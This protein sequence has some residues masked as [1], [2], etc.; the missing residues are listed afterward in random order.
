M[1]KKNGKK[2]IKNWQDEY[3]TYWGHYEYPTEPFKQMIMINKNKKLTEHMNDN[4]IDDE[5][6]FLRHL[7]MKWTGKRF[8][9]NDYGLDCLKCQYWNHYTNYCTKYKIW[10]ESSGR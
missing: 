7:I 2:I 5:T 6:A 10:G 4:I 1:T 3:W 9:C 8:D